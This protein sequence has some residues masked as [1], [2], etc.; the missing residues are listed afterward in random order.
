M[1]AFYF[2]GNVFPSESFRRIH[3][4]LL[5]YRCAGLIVYYTLGFN[6]SSSVQ[7]TLI[8]IKYV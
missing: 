2:D 4:I 1:V 3:Y 5:I 8:L 6:I 7:F